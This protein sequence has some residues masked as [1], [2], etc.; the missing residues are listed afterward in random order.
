[1]NLLALGL[2][3]LAGAMMLVVKQGMAQTLALMALAGLANHH[4][5]HQNLTVS[6]FVSFRIPYA[7]SQALRGIMRCLT[8]LTMVI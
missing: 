2:S 1:M 5:Y 7:D 3:L 4:F 6:P 8:I